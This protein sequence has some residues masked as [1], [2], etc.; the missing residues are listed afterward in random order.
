M[1]FNAYLI[2][3]KYNDLKLCR[4]VHLKSHYG[5]ILVLWKNMIWCGLSDGIYRVFN[6]YNLSHVLTLQRPPSFTEINY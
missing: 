2:E 1:T 6:A 5:I 3:M 4:W